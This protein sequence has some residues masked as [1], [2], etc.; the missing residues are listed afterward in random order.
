MKSYKPIL[1]SWLLVTV[2]LAVVA[3]LSPSGA[4]RR[5]SFERIDLRVFLRLSQNTRNVLIDA[6]TGSDAERTRIPHAIAVADVV[7]EAGK[8]PAWSKVAG[9]PNVIVYAD[10]PTAAYSALALLAKSGIEP[11]K[12]YEGGW[13]E[14]RQLVE[15]F[16]K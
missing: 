7:S 6:R 11:L 9:A 1:W 8:G 2:C 14:W 3:D 5:E 12:F 15:P 16:L 13:T 4:R 10:K